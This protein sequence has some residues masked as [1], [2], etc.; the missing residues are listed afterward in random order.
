MRCRGIGRRRRM[1][2]QFCDRGLRN[3]FGG[4]IG[5]QKRAGRGQE[6]CIKVLTHFLV[7]GRR[8]RLH[9]RRHGQLQPV[10]QLLKLCARARFE[11]RIDGSRGFFQCRDFPFHS[12]QARSESCLSKATSLSSAE[13]RW[14]RPHPKR[15]SPER[16]NAFHSDFQ[17]RSSQETPD[18]LCNQ[19]FIIIKCNLFR[20]IGDAEWGYVDLNNA[21]FGNMPFPLQ[22]RD[23]PA[24]GQSIVH[25]K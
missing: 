10:Y 22:L 9:H 25:H 5:P 12:L 1:R 20:W 13:V 19:S 21:A 16:Y 14:R 8:H 6:L 3:N 2:H 15:H 7:A 11:S 4:S 17:T 24:R 23:R 18:R